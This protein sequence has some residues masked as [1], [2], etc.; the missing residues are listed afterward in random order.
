MFN[1][2]RPIVFGRE[3]HSRISITRQIDEIEI[4]FYSI[5]VDR[6]RAARCVT[7]KRQPAL[8]RKRIDQ[9]G[10]SDIASPQEGYLGQPVGGELLGRT[11]TLDEFRFQFYYT[12]RAGGRKGVVNNI[13]LRQ[14][15]WMTE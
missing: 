6:L 2:F 4:T 11:S 5:K 15:P 7:G 14:Q 13:I 8:S 1:E 10:F 3:G 9:T 12:G